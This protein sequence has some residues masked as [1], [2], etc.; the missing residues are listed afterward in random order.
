MA[1]EEKE[2]TSKKT[3]VLETPSTSQED[4]LLTKDIQKRTR[5]LERQVADIEEQLETIEE[6]IEILEQEL[7]TPDVYLDHVKSTELA[8][9]TSELKEKQTTLMDQWE[10][11]SLELAHL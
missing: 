8:G 4:R 5:Q 1:L 6:E 7:S 2:A 11:L 3:E 10:T 9:Q